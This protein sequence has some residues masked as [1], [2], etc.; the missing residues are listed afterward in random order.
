MD[1]AMNTEL[2]DRGILFNDVDWLGAN[3]ERAD[4]IA[5]I[6]KSYA[7]LG[8]ELHIANSFAIAPLNR[9]AVSVCRRA[10]DRAAPHRQWIAGSI[11]TYAKDHDRDNLPELDVLEEN[12]RQQALVLADAGCD[13]IALE[14]LFDAEH[15]IAM[16]KGA[17][18]AGLP[19][20]IGMV[21]R[22]D[23]SGR[24]LLTRFRVRHPETYR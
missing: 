3:V 18:A 10:I 5:D 24:I 11:S 15:S 23:R 21:A 22:R 19:I 7:R 20:S 12:C 1:G 14:M 13:L 4:V 6:H 17:A 16:L 9:A 8:A 2:S